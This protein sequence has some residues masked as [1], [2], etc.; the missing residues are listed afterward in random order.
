[1]IKIRAEFKKIENMKSI[2][3]INKTKIWFFEK[4]TKTDKTLAR[5]AKKK[6]EGTDS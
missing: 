6:K 5:L 4:M 3:K 1:M 2:E